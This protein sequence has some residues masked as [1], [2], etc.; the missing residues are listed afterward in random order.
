MVCGGLRLC[1][2]A[3]LF[4]VVRGCRLFVVW[5]VVAV[6]CRLLLLVVCSLFGIRLSLRFVV[7]RR[8]LAIVWRCP[9]VSAVVCWLHVAVCGCL[10]FCAQ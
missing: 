3:S 1:V 5:L 6:S 10:L 9:F 2:C 8:V 4:A 7:V